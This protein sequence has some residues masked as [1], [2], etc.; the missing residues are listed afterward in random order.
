LVL[1]IP[2]LQRLPLVCLVLPQHYSSS[3]SNNNSNHSRSMPTLHILR[4][5][6]MLNDW[7]IK[8]IV[9][10][11]RIAGPCSTSHTCLLHCYPC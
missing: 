10:W 9:L 3:S 5:P 6:K 2:R 11:W 7:S 1:V 4:Y 8:F